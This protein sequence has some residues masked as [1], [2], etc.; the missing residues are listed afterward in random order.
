MINSISDIIN[1]KKYKDRDLRKDQKKFLA[2]NGYLLLEPNKNFWEWIGAEPK[3]LRIIMDSILAK[4]GIKAG[5]EGKEEFT[6]KKSKTIE[7]A[8][9]RIGNL[10][11]KN[12]IIKNIATLP[13]I[14]LGAFEVIKDVI[15][16]SSILFREPKKNS[17][18]QDLHID[19]IPRSNLEEKFKSVVTFLYL[20]DS[21]KNNG[22][23]KIVPKSHLKL[24]YPDKYINPKM[25][26]EKEIII[27]AKAGSILILNSLIWHRGGANLTGDKRGIIVTEYRQRALKQLL[28][29]KKYVSRS[30]KKNMSETEKYLF[31]LRENDTNQ[32]EDSA[33]PGDHY[34][35]WLKQNNLNR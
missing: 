1:T 16:L 34:R 7:P 17:G 27:E 6:I 5:S 26:Y 19:W 24:S 23:T 12:E 14:V 28:N 18:E 9:N 30:V 10:L 8:A 15:K 22:A 31:G 20:N 2:E 35:N 4:E 21:N 29:L 13:E 3:D 33:G 11:D 25:P 32:K